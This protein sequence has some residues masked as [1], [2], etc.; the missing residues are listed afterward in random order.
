M[1]HEITPEEGR[2]SGG[3]CTLFWQK[4]LLNI[5]SA[6]KARYLLQSNDFYLLAGKPVALLRLGWKIAVKLQQ[7]GF[8]PLNIHHLLGRLDPEAIYTGKK[9]LISCHKVCLTYLPGSEPCFD[10]KQN[11]SGFCLGFFF[12]A[13]NLR[14]RWEGAVT[15]ETVVGCCA[16]AGQ[17]SGRPL[18]GWWA[19]KSVGCGVQSRPGSS[20]LVAGKAMPGEMLLCVWALV[21][22]SGPGA[23]EKVKSCFGKHVFLRLFF[24]LRLAQLAQIVRRERISQIKCTFA[25][26]LFW[27]VLVFC[28]FPVVPS[29]E[30]PHCCHSCVADAVSEHYSD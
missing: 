17:C 4:S 12:P 7:E 11:C 8:S 5:F 30:L 26:R 19:Q 22:K 13:L 2:G 10:I 3:G 24:C 14:A 27:F 18:L 16:A 1:C 28:P 6:L 25:A 29:Q 21:C 23:L 20:R 9:H 15:L